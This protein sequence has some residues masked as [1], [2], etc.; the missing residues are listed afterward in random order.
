[1]KFTPLDLLVIAAVGVAAWL[2]W[3]AYGAAGNAA[4]AAAAWAEQKTADVAQTWRNA[5]SAPAQQTQK[6]LLYS[7]EA[8]T[9]VDPVTGQGALDGAR[10]SDEFRRYEAE[11]RAGEAAQGLPRS[12]TTTEGAVFGRYPKP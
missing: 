1:M 7:D 4:K 8:Y 5:T 6:A 9:G 11:F 3:K 10:A 2:G 12:T